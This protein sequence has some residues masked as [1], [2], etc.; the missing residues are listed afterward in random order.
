M[1]LEDSINKNTEAL[2]RL[3]SVLAAMPVSAASVGAPAPLTEA[4]KEEA[5]KPDEAQ[6]EAQLSYDN[7]VR[8]PFL[9]LL[10][11][12]RAAAMKVLADLG[13]PNLKGYE[14]KTESYAEVAQKIKEAANG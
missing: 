10:N 7:D 13:V 8:K 2:N 4:P 1:S 5:A 3:V 9:A 14:G 12:N 11:S 6:P